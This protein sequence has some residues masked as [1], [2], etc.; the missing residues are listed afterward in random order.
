MSTSIQKQAQV[1]TAQIELPSKLQTHLDSLYV[2]LML[3][4]VGWVACQALALF[5]TQHAVIQHEQT[6][7]GLQRLS[8]QHVRKAPVAHQT[9]SSQIARDKHIVTPV[10]TLALRGA[11]TRLS[12]L[13]AGSNEP[14]IRMLGVRALPLE[15]QIKMWL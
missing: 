5:P 4:S 2:L 1:H 3:S 11:S 15:Q 14:L 10:M 8:V 9:Q 6:H 13:S 7:V 12:A